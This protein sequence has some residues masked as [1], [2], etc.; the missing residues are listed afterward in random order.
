MF[1]IQTH[2]GLCNCMH[3]FYIVGVRKRQNYVALALAI[4]KVK[5]EKNSNEIEYCV[6]HFYQICD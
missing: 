2:K 6:W 5:T 1:E 4:T 3:S